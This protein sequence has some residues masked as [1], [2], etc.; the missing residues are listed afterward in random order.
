MPLVDQTS[1]HTEIVMITTPP[2]G[3]QRDPTKTATPARVQTRG[4]D[5]PPR[6]N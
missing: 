2:P 1:N 3:T 4:R 6:V 5:S